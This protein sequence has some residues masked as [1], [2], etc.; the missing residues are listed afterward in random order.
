MTLRR[1]E[2]MVRNSGKVEV[3]I[4]CPCHKMFCHTLLDFLC[5]LSNGLD[6]ILL[7]EYEVRVYMKLSIFGIRTCTWIKRK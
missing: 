7:R 5:L 6:G 4:L 2:L 1:T 3:A